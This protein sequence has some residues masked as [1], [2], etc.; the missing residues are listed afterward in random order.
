MQYNKMRLAVGLFIITL[1]LVLVGSIFFLL[2]EKGVFDKRYTYH[3]T[4]DS[5]EYFS[6]GMP[7]KF[8]GFNIGVIDDISLK[9]D[10]SV[11]MSFSVSQKN[12]RWLSQGSILIIIKPLL[13][14]PH[15]ELY[16]SADSPLLDDGAI[17]TILLSDNINDL[18]IKL[19]PAVQ[20]AVNILNSIDKITTYLT[21]ENSELKQILKNLNKFSAKLANNDSLLTSATGDKAS[22]QNIIKSINET[23]EIMKD[24]KKITADVSRITASLKQDIVTPASSSIKE[25]DLIMK[26]INAKLK[27][28]NPTVEAIGSYDTELIELKEQLSVGVQKSNQIMDK[29]DS[30]MQDEKSSEV[31][32][33]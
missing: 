15:I 22:T 6:V 2:K 11:Y 9:D 5:A 18:I 14:S 28:I 21:S 20:K 10:G 26:D 23:A 31:L 4:T 27:T 33:P 19:Q 3:F 29:I 1:F 17:L 8:S 16:T 24:I 30:L 13:G 7:L 12:R 32:L 25:I